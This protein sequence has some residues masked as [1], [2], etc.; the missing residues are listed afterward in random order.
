[1]VAKVSRR[2]QCLRKLVEPRSNIIDA[3]NYYCYTCLI[4]ERRKKKKTKEQG[5]NE[6]YAC[7]YIYTRV[8]TLYLRTKVYHT[9]INYNDSPNFHFGKREYNSDG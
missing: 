8:R 7:M 1:M 3:Y 2:A 4:Q 9:R 5:G 6:K